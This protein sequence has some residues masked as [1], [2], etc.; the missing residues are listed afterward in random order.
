MR[1]AV[2]DVDMDVWVGER[3]IY[4]VRWVTV[5]C[6]MRYTCVG[7]IMMKMIIRFRYIMLIQ[8]DFI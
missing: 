1:V 3:V 4:A 7:K 6:L 2:M 8:L 5:G